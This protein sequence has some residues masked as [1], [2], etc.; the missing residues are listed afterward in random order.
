VTTAEDRRV[1][2][3]RYRAR[4]KK[5]IRAAEQRKF[6]E[7]LS[8]RNEKSQQLAESHRRPWQGF[9]DDYLLTGGAS[10]AE[11]A[12]VLGRTLFAVRE[13]RKVL[14]RAQRAAGAGASA[15]H[16]ARGEPG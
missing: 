8:P 10:V 1:Y 5:Q 7:R 9:E 12:A 16:S 4:H 11:A 13:R 15:P 3:R 2:R 14:R 6:T